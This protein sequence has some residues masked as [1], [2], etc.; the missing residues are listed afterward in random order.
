MHGEGR[1]GIPLRAVWEVR[2]GLLQTKQVMVS[3]EGCWQ[4]PGC[5]RTSHVP[6]AT[7]INSD[8]TVRSDQIS[9]SVVSNS[10]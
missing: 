10:L 2:K 9:R 8:L 6:I 3:S 1:E 7:L 4:H 5:G